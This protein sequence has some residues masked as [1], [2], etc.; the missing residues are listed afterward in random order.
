LIFHYQV[1]FTKAAGEIPLQKRKTL[2]A[3]KALGCVLPVTS[4]LTSA[5]GRVLQWPPGHW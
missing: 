3:Q 5:P 1:D 2:R 4:R